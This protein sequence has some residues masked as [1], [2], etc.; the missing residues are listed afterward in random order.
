MRILSDML[1]DGK[2]ELDSYTRFYDGWEQVSDLVYT[3]IKNTNTQELLRFP[4]GLA[5]RT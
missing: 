5:S 2:I 1:D 3:K 4:F